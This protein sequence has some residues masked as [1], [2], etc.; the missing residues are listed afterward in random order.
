MF[1]LFDGLE[2]P[3]D[4]SR[5]RVRVPLSAGI[6]SAAVLCGL[7][8]HHPEHLKPLELHLYYAHLQEHS[9][10]SFQF[11]ADLVRYAR[12]TF[13]VV[14]VRITRDSV[15]KYFIE[16]KMIP[17][18]MISPCSRELKIEPMQRYDV[19]HGI[20][21][22]LIGY[23]RHEIKRYTRAVA[24][25]VATSRT[26]DSY[27]LLSWTDEDCLEL[28]KNVIGWYPAI[29]DI[30]W[31]RQDWL[32]GLCRKHEIGRRVFTHNNCLPCKNMTARQIQMVG[33]HFPS[34]AIIAQ[35][36]ADRIPGAYWGRD[37]VPDVFKCDACDRM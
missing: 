1:S 15:N 27:P 19:E 13:P 25:A 20:D 22:V 16:Q 18:P 28:V 17:H 21:V 37:D 31:T 3:I 5:S 36:T 29:Y 7:G 9:S 4:Y 24:R 14:K 8:E 12:R 2:P 32:I 26:K 34:Y 11:V 23:V 35:A 10:D 33:R 30:K 6:N